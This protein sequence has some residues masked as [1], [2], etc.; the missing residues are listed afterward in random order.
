MCEHQECSKKFDFNRGLHE[1]LTGDLE[2]F[3]ATNYFK[4]AKIGIK[5][6]DECN[7]INYYL[8]CEGELD[9]E[10]DHEFLKDV[11]KAFDEC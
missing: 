4:D 10:E 11:E 2:K 6:K 3:P 7:G 5:R 8:Y 1:D 9:D